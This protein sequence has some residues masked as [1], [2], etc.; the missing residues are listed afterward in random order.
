[1]SIDPH[2][3]ESTDYHQKY[4]REVEA[5]SP[6]EARRIVTKEFNEKKLPIYWIKFN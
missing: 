5:T 1:M 6:D 3:S 2:S 4:E